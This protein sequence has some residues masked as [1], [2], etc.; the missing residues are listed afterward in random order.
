MKKIIKIVISF[1]LLL[2]IT[3]TTT[4]VVKA[5]NPYITRTT[6]RF[7]EL[8]ETQDAY[9][10]IQKIKDLGGYSLNK[11]TDLYI[12][13]EDYIYIADT[14]NKKIVV[15]DPNHNLILSFGDDTLLSPRGI[16]V[17][18]NVLYVA[19]YGDHS[20]DDSGQ[21]VLYDIDKT[22]P[23]ATLKEIRKCPDSQ[24]LSL[25]SFKY[26]PEKI[27][28]DS[29]LTMYVVSEGSY[30]G[31][32]TI[33]NENRFIS[34][35]APNNV[36][37]SIGTKI[38]QFLYGENEKANIKSILPTPPYNVHI[39]DSGYIY[40][41]S[42][43]VVKNEIGD[44]LKKV[45]IG[46][47]NYYPNQMLASSDFVACWSGK[48]GNVYAATQSG[49]IYEY[50]INGNLIFIFAGPATTIDQLGLFKNIMGIAVNNEDEIY[51]LDQN[52]NSIQIF[53]PTNFTNTVHQA[54][55]LFNEGR[56]QESQSLWEEVLVFNSMTD[57]A[58]KGI[59][60][61]FFMKGE[62]EEALKEFKL[63][64]DKEN[65]SEAFWEIRN[66]WISNNILPLFIIIV[67]LIVA[68]FVISILNKKKH[69]LEPINNAFMKAKEK[70]PVN[71]FL[72]MFKMLRHPYDATYYIKKDKKIRYY[73]GLIVLLLLFVIYIVSLVSTGFI[74]NNVVLERTVL[75]KEAFK[76]LIPIVLFVVANYLASSLLEGEGTFRAIF[77][78]TMAA[79]MPIVVIYPFLI[80]VSNFITYSE[81]FIYY[82][83]ITI[84][85]GWSAVILLLVNKELHN[86]TFKKMILNI[87][88]TVLL[89]LVLLIVVI[90]CYLMVSQ[91][92]TFIKDVISEVIFHE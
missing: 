83:G 49:F 5:E 71:D 79:L 16:Y 64:N 68:I 14:G 82:F 85:I 27:A 17:R 54:L 15:L 92:I 80:I 33:N 37:V 61:S 26:H 9:E 32:L 63:A 30:S 81:S 24:V 31:V 4:N 88:M 75:L 77:L 13:D 2:S 78:T 19:D 21:I 89:M 22:L 56:Y 59:G 60:L 86:Y 45:N 20:V 72:L 73:N 11:P 29:N 48:Y 34:Y 47:V 8:V 57:I 23:S 46:G 70:K 43:M 10:A 76:I 25:S 53:T 44:T 66:V 84:M 90:L 58:H 6:N 28:V 65:Y 18:D 7:D 62:Y 87:I 3:L 55:G 91:V 39:D 50:D 74:F 52:D 12:D 35:F 40:T 38:L 67:L 51:I 36:D 69:I 1:I 42:Q 41:V